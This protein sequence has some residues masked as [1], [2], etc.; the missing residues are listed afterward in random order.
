MS[1]D[2]YKKILE[3]KKLIEKRKAE[4]ALK[5]KEK[6]KLKIIWTA[7]GAALIVLVLLLLHNYK[8]NEMPDSNR[9]I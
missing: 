1:T 9:C 6:K 3:Q 4:L 2:P 5:K 8:I 7:I